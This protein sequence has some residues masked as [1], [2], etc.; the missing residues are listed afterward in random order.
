MAKYLELSKDQ[1]ISFANGTTIGGYTLATPSSTTII[2]GAPALEV[3]TSTANGWSLIFK[4]MGDAKEI[5]TLT[6]T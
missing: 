2:D 4:V 6:H 5:Y 3:I 1:L